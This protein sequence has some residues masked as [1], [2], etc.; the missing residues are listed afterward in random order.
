MLNSEIT[1]VI[2]KIEGTYGVDAVPSASTDAI[3]CSKPKITPLDGDYKDRDIIRGYYGAAEKLPGIFRSKI[4]FDIEIAGSGTAG[5]A[6]AWGRLLRACSCSEVSLA[7]A[8]TGTAQAGA[9]G[10]LTLAATGSA[11]NDAYRGMR[12]R[13][14]GGQGAGQSRVIA[15]Y[16]GTTKL[17]AVT[18]NWTT[19]PNNTSVYSIDAQTVYQPV[20]TGQSSL[21]LYFHIDGVLHRIVGARGNA[22]MKLASGDIPTISFEYIGL[23]SAATD[24]AVPAATL[25]AWQVPVVVGPDNSSGFSL[26][27][28]AGALKSLDMDVGSKVSHRALIGNNSVNI[29]GRVA[30]GSVTMEAT[31]VAQRDWWTTVRNAARGALTLTHGT[32]AGN[33]VDITAPAVQITS[34]QYDDDDGVYNLSGQLT[35]LPLNGNDDFSLIVR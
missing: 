34:P 1:L 25:T 14:T 33:I 20:S 23:Y 9:S 15:S 27:G 21:T 6:P 35:L 31:T 16:N 11:V 22:K 17:A 28:Y 13:I 18:E 12:V 2:A 10:S 3:L 8:H 24:V 5:T 7:T 4:E 32:A 29:N 30:S 26:H 19:V